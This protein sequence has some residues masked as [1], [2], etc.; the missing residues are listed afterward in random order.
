MPRA[1]QLILVFS[2]GPDQNPR[3]CDVILV[4]RSFPSLKQG[5]S[6]VVALTATERRMEKGI[7]LK[8]QGNMLTRVF[9]IVH[10]RQ[11]KV[12]LAI[13]TK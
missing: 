10:A 6:S 7:G 11:T 2:P 5:R 13:F 8:Q 9:L 3:H 4:V 12:T 1:P